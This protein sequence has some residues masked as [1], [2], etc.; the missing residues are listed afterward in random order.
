[1]KL[2]HKMGKARKLIGKERKKE[3]RECGIGE[4]RNVNKGKRKEI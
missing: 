2:T 3:T 1:L 4:S